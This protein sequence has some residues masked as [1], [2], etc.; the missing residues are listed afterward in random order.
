MAPTIYITNRL[1]TNIDF[2]N[3]CGNNIDFEIGITYNRT[4]KKN[5]E[6]GEYLADVSLEL[7][8]K[9]EVDQEIKT[10][11]IRFRMQVSIKCLEDGLTIS[12][13]ADSVAFELYPEVRSNM[14]MLL[15]LAGL[16]QILLPISLREMTR[17]KESES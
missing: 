7:N 9:D 10:F 13:I 16:P 15:L 5:E 14:A 11:L 6:S 1:V 3:H 8:R 12:E 17:L 4:I 2:I